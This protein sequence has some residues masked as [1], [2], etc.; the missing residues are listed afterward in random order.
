MPTVGSGVWCPLIQRDIGAVAECARSCTDM[1]R[2]IRTN[3]FRDESHAA[4]RNYCR[5]AAASQCE[6]WQKM[7]L[8]TPVA[9]TMAVAPSKKCE[10]NPT[11]P[12]PV[13]RCSPSSIGFVTSVGAMVQPPA[14]LRGSKTSNS[15]RNAPKIGRLRETFAKLSTPAYR[16]TLDVAR[17]D[18]ARGSGKQWSACTTRTRSKGRRRIAILW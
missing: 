17:S 4:E 9:R 7:Y 16:P 12:I 14:R 3:Q 10:E 11:S 1:K 18:T 5:Y 15:A 8:L 6:Q 13:G 2:S